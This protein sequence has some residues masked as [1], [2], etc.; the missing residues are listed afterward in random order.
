[1]RVGI[2]FAL[3]RVGGCISSP[4]QHNASCLRSHTQL[5]AT[6]RVQGCLSCLLPLAD[7]PGDSIEL[8][9]PLQPQHAALC[10][11]MAAMIAF[12]A[13]P[14][15]F[16]LHISRPDARHKKVRAW[17]V[18]GHPLPYCGLSKAEVTQVRVATIGEDKLLPQCK[19]CKLGLINRRVTG[20]NP[21]LIYCKALG[22]WFVLIVYTSS[23]VLKGILES[24]WNLN[25]FVCCFLD[26][27]SLT[28]TYF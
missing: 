9:S 8:L 19:Q 16:H 5:A 24:L 13:A 17:T 28:I 11:Q 1:M 4:V 26:I 23:K 27:L 25:C 3:P 7:G 10:L 12:S 21:L 22:S 15:R 6:E 18:S 2:V 20:K 14:G